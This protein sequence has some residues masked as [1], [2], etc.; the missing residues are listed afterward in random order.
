MKN[1][2]D[3]YDRELLTNVPK[4]PQTPEDRAKVYRFQQWI[5]MLRNFAEIS[6]MEEPNELVGYRQD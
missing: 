4:D 2:R 1:E 6:G 5:H 3:T